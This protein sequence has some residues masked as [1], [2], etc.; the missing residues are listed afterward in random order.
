M[1]IGLDVNND[2]NIAEGYMMCE[3]DARKKFTKETPVRFFAYL[4]EYLKDEGIE[5]LDIDVE[6]TFN[7]LE[8]MYFE[9]KNSIDS[10]A[11]TNNHVD[12][13]NPTIY[14]ALNLANDIKG[15]SGLI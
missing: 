12:F 6:L 9:N 3:Y 13:N 2:V 15:Y 4:P 8:E 14:D 5:G 1:V 10:F 11:E 7:E